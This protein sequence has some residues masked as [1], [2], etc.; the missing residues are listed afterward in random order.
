MLDDIRIGLVC[1]ISSSDRISCRE[2]V[3]SFSS[4]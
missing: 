3:K 1:M 4:S 2:E